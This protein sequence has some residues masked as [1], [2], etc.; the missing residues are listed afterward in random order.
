MGMGMGMAFQDLFF[1]LCIQLSMFMYLRSCSRL[2]CRLVYWWHHIEPPELKWA[3]K[4]KALDAMS[5]RNGGV[6]PKTWIMQALFVQYL[7]A[8]KYP[9]MQ[10]RAL[11]EPKT[12]IMQTLFVQYYH[13][14]EYLYMTYL[15]MTSLWM[16]TCECYICAR[17]IFVNAIGVKL[18][19]ACLPSLPWVFSPRPKLNACV[20]R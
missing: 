20:K 4:L 15:C 6:E 2:F 14:L 8:L 3:F 13:A 11:Q 17:H 19:Y 1:M 16:Y 7:H 5:T 10:P 12:W 18:D 9:K